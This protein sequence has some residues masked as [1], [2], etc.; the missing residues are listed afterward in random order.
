MRSLVCTFAG[1]FAP[2][3]IVTTAG[4]AQSDR[5]KEVNWLEIQTAYPADGNLQQQFLYEASY[6]TSQLKQHNLDH[7]ALCTH[8]AFRLEGSTDGFGRI[9]VY[10]LDVVNE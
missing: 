5:P 1:G 10:K 2:I 7:N 3:R 8:L 4:F 9:I 6:L